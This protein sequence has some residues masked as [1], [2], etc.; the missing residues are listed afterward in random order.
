[1]SVADDRHF[2]MIDQ[3]RADT[4]QIDEAVDAVLLE[5]PAGPIPESISSCGVTSEP[6]ATMISPSA[7]TVCSCPFASRYTT[8][9]ARPFSMTMRRARAL[10]PDR[11][12]RVVLS[13]ARNA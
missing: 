3:V 5:L 2:R 11:Q 13:G 4:R 9:T 7:Y 12:T 6:A 8:P 1:M 10:Q